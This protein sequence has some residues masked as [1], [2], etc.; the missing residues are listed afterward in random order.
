MTE[1]PRA[2]GSERP[3]ERDDS[4]L[5][6]GIREMGIAD[7][8]LLAAVLILPL[9]PTEVAGVPWRIIALEIIAFAALVLLPLRRNGFDPFRRSP[10]NPLDRWILAWLGVA[11]V[12]IAVAHLPGV[13]VYRFGN[14]LALAALY[15]AF[16]DRVRTFSKALVFAAAAGVAALGVAVIELIFGGVLARLMGEGASFKVE[17]RLFM[18][19]YLAAQYI[20]PVLMLALSFALNRGSRAL[21][22]GAV[23]IALPMGLYL[24]LMGS[25]GVYL[26]FIASIAFIMSLTALRHAEGHGFRR[27][28]PA[29]R[30]ALPV[31]AL[32]GVGIFVISSA[33]WLGEAGTHAVDRIESLFDP[34]EAE[35]NFSRLDIWTDSMPMSRDALLL[36]VGQGN[37]GLVLPAYHMDVK[38][39]PHAHNQIIQILCE[40]GVA[41][42]LCFVA[43]TVVLIGCIR[44][45]AGRPTGDDEAFAA[46]SGAAGALVAAG[47][48]GFFETPLE[49]PAS[50]V[51]FLIPITIL[52]IPRRSEA[53]THET[54]GARFPWAFLAT[55]ALLAWIFPALAMVRA[56]ASGPPGDRGFEL[57]QA[58][59]Y[60]EAA[61][62]LSAADEAWP[63]RPEILE[64]EALARF[65]A[66]EFEGALEAARRS[67]ALRPGVASL[68][69]LSGW[70]LMH[71][72]R[73]GEARDH[74]KEAMLRTRPKH[75][76][77]IYFDLGRAY[78]RSG[79]GE[80]A[81]NVFEDLL[82]SK[83]EPAME[84]E[85][86]LELAMTLTGLGRD[87]AL[88]LTRVRRAFHRARGL[89]S[90]SLLTRIVEVMEH[91]AEA[92]DLPKHRA[93]QLERLKAM[94][95]E[96]LEALEAE[97]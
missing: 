33:G 22:M 26:T 46:R 75:R 47:I 92:F 93:N 70:C 10:G 34:E 96:A 73:P 4:G 90:A 97:G 52:L 57:F 30:F 16:T 9:L 11:A 32:A 23:L 39:I 81:L 51:F 65:E 20:L 3:P 77:R 40:N 43:V 89:G 2:A 95:L 88:A 42:L 31:V 74:F 87:E 38:H 64:M 14:M 21:R 6:R 53:A 50:Q 91:M 79:A 71:L 76:R 24:F 84:A 85:L 7:I 78:R 69:S 29:F 55:A 60:A 94:A 48:H 72:E 12:G 18:H 59:R 67:L 25:R 45:R 54:E 19:A 49:W 37:Y 13:A 41:G 83:P 17:S 44:R 68:S 5:V 8:P 80:A 86:D 56:V 82:R 61:E 66:K 28:V 15:Y 62:T 1:S 58:G 27:F 63:Y 36:G 35:F